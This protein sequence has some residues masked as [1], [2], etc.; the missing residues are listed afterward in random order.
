MLDGSEII[1]PFDASS[2]AEQLLRH[3]CRI[4][5][6]EDMLLSVLCGVEQPAGAAPH[7]APPD[8]GPVL[9]ALVRA[10]EICREEGVAPALELRCGHSL[11]DAILEEAERSGATLVCVK[12]GERR[13]GEAVFGAQSPTDGLGMVP[14]GR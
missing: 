4:A 13:R 11:T 5:R 8:D 3:A 14:G 12:L 9:T 7:E 2:G 10:Q 1:V 6:A